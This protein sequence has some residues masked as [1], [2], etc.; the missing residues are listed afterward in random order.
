MA[1]VEK[2]VN[3]LKAHEG[4]PLGI[5]WDLIECSLYPEEDSVCRTL[6]D[7]FAS[8]VL[9]EKH[10]RNPWY[11]KSHE[12]CQAVFGQFKKE[13]DGAKGTT[14]PSKEAIKAA[15]KSLKENRKDAMVYLLEDYVEAAAGSH[16]EDDEDAPAMLA[17]ECNNPFGW[18]DFCD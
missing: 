3:F 7:T 1:Q 11:K 8:C 14:P 18:D 9:N 5:A 12:I 13:F 15:L 17:Q 4:D 10:S 16:S 6:A 2:L